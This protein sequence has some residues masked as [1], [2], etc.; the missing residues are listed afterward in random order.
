[1]RMILVKGRGLNGAKKR[2]YFQM[3]WPEAGGAEQQN[4]LPDILESMGRAPDYMRSFMLRSDAPF[5]IG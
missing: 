5:S 4:W 1:M 3:F 2:V